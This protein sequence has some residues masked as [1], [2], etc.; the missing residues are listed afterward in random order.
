LH[1]VILWNGRLRSDKVSVH[2][3][4]FMLDY[5]CKPQIP[6]YLL[7]FFGSLHSFNPYAF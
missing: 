7:S 3:L 1:P 6:E 5:P 2:S 4:V